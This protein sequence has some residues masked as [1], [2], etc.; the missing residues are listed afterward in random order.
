MFQCAR[1]FWGTL[2]D[3]QRMTWNAT[4]NQHRTRTVL[5]QSAH[6][7]GYRGSGARTGLG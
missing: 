1:A 5:G 7:S 3:E 2:T 6:L 4:A